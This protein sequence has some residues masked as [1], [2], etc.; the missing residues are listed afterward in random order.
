[1]KDYAPLSINA[2]NTLR[3][4]HSKETLLR[5]Y[6]HSK[7]NSNNDFVCNYLKVLYQK[8]GL[9]VKLKTYP[10]NCVDLNAQFYRFIIIIIIM[11]PTHITEV[12]I[13]N[14]WI[15]SDIAA[16]FRIVVV[17]AIVNLK[18]CKNNA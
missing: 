6:Y 18:S 11:L 3:S 15:F 10:S 13:L 4:V 17:L 9:R 7:C 14:T 8:E 16:K 1:M 5:V 2:N 12:Q